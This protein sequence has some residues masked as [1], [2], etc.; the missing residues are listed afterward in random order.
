MTTY[1]A[2]GFDPAPG[3][4][5]SVAELL[6]TATHVS[7]ELSFLHG[8]LSTF[9]KVG[10]GWEGQA[11]T[12]FTHRLGDLPTYLNA[13]NASAAVAKRALARWIEQLGGFQDEARRY[14]QLAEEAQRA[15][16]RAQ[17][18][19]AA[20]Q[21]GTAPVDPVAAAAAARDAQAAQEAVRLAG[22]HLQDIIRAAEGLYGEHQQHADAI[23]G[24]LREAADFAPPK[25]GFFSRIKQSLADMADFVTSLPGKIKQ[26]I[27]DHAYLIKAIADVLADVATVLGVVAFFLPPPADLIVGAIAAGASLLALG[28]HALAAYGGAEVSGWTYLADTIGIASFGFAKIGAMGVKGSK[29]ALAA[30]EASGA[31]GGVKLSKESIAYYEKVGRYY[32][33]ETA[34]VGSGVGGVQTRREGGFP[35]EYWVPHT[36]GQAVLGAVSPIG[37]AMWNGAHEGMDHDHEIHQREVEEAWLR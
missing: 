15:V 18:H 4:V 22:Q 28:G 9:G 8:K 14:E 17:S 27:H 35:F 31:L 32:S 33:A 37:L 10:S 24:M 23:A 34:A 5:G 30:H 21:G 11:A 19:A 20:L 25:P 26:F 29:E 16:T 2:L 1:P 3:R 13:A 7:S 12:E 36:P 6:R